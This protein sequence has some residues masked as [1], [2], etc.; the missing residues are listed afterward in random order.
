LKSRRLME[1]GDEAMFHW[2]WSLTRIDWIRMPPT[3]GISLYWQVFVRYLQA[4][5]YTGCVAIPMMRLKRWI[6][7]LNH[8]EFWRQWKVY[9]ATKLSKLNNLW[10]YD[11]T[12]KTLSKWQRNID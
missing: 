3:S 12:A 2:P 10:A 1:R 6:E 4:G 8:K 11:W 5:F 9:E 7:V